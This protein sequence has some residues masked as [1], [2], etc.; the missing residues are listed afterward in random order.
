MPLI[1]TARH[2][3]CLEADV[4]LWQ[5]LLQNSAIGGARQDCRKFVNGP[6]RRWKISGAG[7]VGTDEELV[8]ASEIKGGG[9]QVTYR[10]ITS[11]ASL[12]ST[13]GHSFM[14]A[15]LTGR[16]SSAVCQAW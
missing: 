15:V 4:A 16:V 11:E 10:L 14:V 12:S 1:R 9:M 7:R 2:A 8:C 5:I 13:A 3:I 6:V